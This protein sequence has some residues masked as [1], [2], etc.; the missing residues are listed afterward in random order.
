MVRHGIAT[1]KVG[2]NIRN[3]AQRPLIDAGREQT[4]MVCNALKRLGTKPD[5][6]VSSPFVRARQT[7]EIC[8]EVFG[9]KDN[10]VYSD[11]LTPGGQVSDLYKCL[12]ELK[13]AEEVFLFGH[14]PD[15]TRLAQALLWAS[16]DFDMPFKKSGVARI[17]VFDLPPTSPGT[18]R[19]LLTPDLIAA[20]SLNR[21]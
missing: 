4:Q 8:A 13:R 7:A 10:L 1:E 20:V 12:A 11:A 14:Q 9:Q 2:G 3:D 19:W 18:L 5:Y 16:P 17:D 21:G 6:L 15:M